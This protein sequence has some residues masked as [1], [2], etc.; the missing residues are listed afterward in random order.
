[1]N[2]QTNKLL[3]ESERSRRV[4]LSL[5]ED[6]KRAEEALRAR[7]Q[8]T[9]RLHEVVAKLTVSP[10]LIEGNLKEFASE[11]NESV[12]EALNIERI[13]VWLFNS[14]QSELIC[15]DL[16]QL[17]KNLHTHGGVLKEEEFQ[18]EFTYLKTEKFVDA[19]NPLTDPRTAGYVEGY[20]KPNN[21]TSMLDA[22][23]RFG[24]KNL[25]SLCFEHVNVPHKWEAEEITFASQLADQVAIALY[26]NERKKTLEALREN[27]SKFRTLADFTYDWEY[28]QSETGEVIYT[29]PSCFRI[30]GYTQEEIIADPELLNKMIHP[31]DVKIF[32]DHHKASDLNAAHEGAEDIEFRIIGKDGMVAVVAHLCRAIY[33]ENKIYRGRRVS[34]RDITSKNQAD[35]KLKKQYENLSHLFIFTNVVSRAESLEKVYDKAIDSILFSLNANR[36][37][38]LLFDEHGVMK[39]VAWRNLSDT[40]RKACEGHSPWKLDTA[41]PEPVFVTNV[42]REKELHELQTVILNE[43]IRSLAFIPLVNQGALIGKVMVYYNALHQFTENEMHLLKTFSSTIAFAIYQK[44]AEE[45]LM[46]SEENY[47]KLVD[48]ASDIIFT[49]DSKGYLVYANP[50]GLK[51]FCDPQKDLSRIHYLDFIVPE[52]R[53]HTFKIY[54]KQFNSL[55][56]LALLEVKTF[57]KDG[58]TI[59]LEENIQLLKNEKEVEGFHVVARNI[60]ERKEA[61]SALE[62]SET[63]F[64][65]L[66]EESADP[67]LLLDDNGFFACNQSTVSLLGYST[68]AE[69]LKKQPWEL[70]PEYQP[71]GTLSAQK[72]EQMILKAIRDGY[73]RFEWIHLK[74]DGTEFPVE[75][76][77]TSITIKGKQSF[78]TVWRD[79][80]HQKLAADTL[81]ESELKYRELV[82]N[83]PDAIAIYVE[84]KIVFL[85]NE[86]VRLMGAKNREEL[87]GKPVMSFV[88]P[89]SRQMVLERMK[90]VM[91]ESV[92]LPPAEEKFIRFNGEAVDVEV[93]A[94]SIK[95]EHHNAVQL[96]IRDISARKRMTEELIA[97][98]ENAEKANSVKDGFIAN[99]S[100]EIRTPLNGILGITSIIKDTFSQYITA[101]EEFFFEGI[102]R[103]SQ[104]IIRTIDMILNFSRLQSGDFPIEPKMIN[105]SSICESLVKDFQP[106]AKGA[107]LK[108]NFENHFGEAILFADEY[109]VSHSISNLIDNAI[110]YTKAGS[111]TVVLSTGGAAEVLLEVR[112][113]GIGM[114]EEYLPYLF[115]PYRQEEMGYGRAY[116]G[117]GL[118]LSLVKKFLD[119]NNARISIKSKKG[120]GSVFSV[121]FNVIQSEKKSS[122]KL[123]ANNGSKEKTGA[124]NSSAQ[125]VK[126]KVLIVE[127]DPINQITINQF[128][129]NLYTGIITSSADQVMEKLRTEN[130][131]LILMDI[132]I[133]GTK[134]GLDLTRELK[135]LNAYRHIPVI[136][137]TAHAFD[138]DKQNAFAAGC[139]DYLSKPFTKEALLKVI[140]NTLDN[141]S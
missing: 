27:E 13:S 102:D 121:V 8:T 97:A 40:Y 34:N 44:R 110:K 42:E 76:M 56:P 69:F 107:S 60:T 128:I 111:V 138:A 66:F 125:K 83:S 116:E 113:T 3:E 55:N 90:Q 84:G 23:I 73:N 6:Q 71:C 7:H 45:A 75:V 18:N 133:S 134:N 57:T 115:E 30:T 32:R 77:L 78:Y 5:L 105:L 124:E 103:S 14:D 46:V 38:L 39:F 104:R 68:R 50:V 86:C 2:V 21:I 140:A 119:L 95:F 87:L 9:M 106:F 89:G 108:L 114:N 126:Q 67:I 109:T 41:N 31:D 101:E 35:E 22:V 59:W 51:L 48:I 88:H 85:N 53:E 122:P 12:A 49:T 135:A 137:I 36:A 20:L 74:A 139:D 11:L 43:G 98:K 24:G 132:S 65:R 26:H 64:K 96:I 92:V 117:V 4:L 131:S 28:W 54:N 129:K 62:E 61:E 33:D 47:R 29:S 82:E 10:S 52:Q 37:A 17:S 80:T 1:M 123:N 16:F 100:H 81:K 99:M 63:T 15:T 79:I 72:G 91:S 58:R 120:E 118:G 112:D 19:D 93:K 25:G 141:H 130:V 127:D 94:M 136:A 70:S